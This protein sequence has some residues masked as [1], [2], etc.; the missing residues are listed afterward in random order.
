MDKVQERHGAPVIS[1][2]CDQKNKLLT[3]LKVLAKSSIDCDAIHTWIP[4]ID[5]MMNVNT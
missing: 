4:S 1:V 3:F 5:L 2:F